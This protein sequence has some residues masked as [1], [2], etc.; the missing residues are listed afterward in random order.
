[1]MILGT[2]IVIVLTGSLVGDDGSS[3]VDEGFE[4]KK[5]TNITF[6]ATVLN[7]QRHIS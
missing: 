2:S 4:L 6:R 7:R 5:N 3:T 1:M